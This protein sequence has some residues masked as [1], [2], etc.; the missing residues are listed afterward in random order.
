MAEDELRTER[1]YRAANQER[2]TEPVRLLTVAE[3]AQILQLSTKQ[4]YRLIRQDA[5]PA[6]RL[7]PGS[8]RVDP[9]DLEEFLA[10]RRP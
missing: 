1:T 3:T 10:A 4:I 8:L 9:S 2:R 7:G 6:V 5:L